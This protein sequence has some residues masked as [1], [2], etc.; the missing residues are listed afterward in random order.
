MGR[1]LEKPAPLVNVPV[2]SGLANDHGDHRDYHCARAC[3]HALVHACVHN[4]GPDRSPAG[5]HCDNR[6]PDDNGAT[7]DNS[8]GTACSSLAD[9]QGRSGN[10]HTDKAL[11][12][13]KLLNGSLHAPSN[14][15][16]TL[17]MPDQS[18]Q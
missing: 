18:E 12:K 17:T 7:L 16:H 11:A 1:T 9:K 14:R 8:G 5:N 6:A 13:S 10:R 15:A 3:A 4:G 2:C